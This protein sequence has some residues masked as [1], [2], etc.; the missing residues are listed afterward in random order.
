VGGTAVS[1]SRR[2]PRLRVNKQTH[3]IRFE[4]ET[5]EAVE[6]VVEPLDTIPKGD[7]Q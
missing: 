2:D 1:A 5:E 4:H 3:R 7:K 6:I